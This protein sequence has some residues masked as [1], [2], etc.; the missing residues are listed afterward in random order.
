MSTPVKH[1][2]L[3]SRALAYI[4]AK[5]LEYPGKKLIL[6]VDEAAMHFNLSPLDARQLEQCFRTEPQATKD[7]HTP[8][9]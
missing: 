5:R 3:V 2:E 7:T 8:C 1:S 6:L 4:A 9:V